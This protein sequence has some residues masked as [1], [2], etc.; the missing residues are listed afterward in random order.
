MLKYLLRRLV[1]PP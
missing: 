1:V